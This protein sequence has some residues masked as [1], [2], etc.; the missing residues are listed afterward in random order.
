[1]SKRKVELTRAERRWA[2]RRGEHWDS[3][4]VA[5]VWPQTRKAHFEVELQRESFVVALEPKLARRL[6]NAA[7]RKGISPHKLLNVW[8]QEGLAK[9]TS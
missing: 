9:A 1:M 5:D 6:T 7:T 3:H 2:L 8:I 4:S